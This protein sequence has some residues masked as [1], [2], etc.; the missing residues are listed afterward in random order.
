[1]GFALLGE[2]P[3]EG[4]PVLESWRALES[5]I[6]ELPPGHEYELPSSVGDPAVARHVESHPSPYVLHVVR[7][8]Q[9][10]HVPLL[11]RVPY[12]L[13]DLHVHRRDLRVIVVLHRAD[14]ASG[15]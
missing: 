15:H 12:Q 9:V 8:H 14:Y 2:C 4:G 5:E 7:G 6:S 1:M 10:V 3:D 13:R 11:R